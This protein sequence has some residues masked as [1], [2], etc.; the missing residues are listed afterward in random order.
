MET[1]DSPIADLKVTLVELRTMRDEIRV[2]LHLAGMDAK[3][4]WDRDLEPRLFSL[5]KRVE[6]EL[7]AA[8]KTVLHD[9]RHA[10]HAF[11]E[12]LKKS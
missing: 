1:K 7:S 10:M 4:K 8:T 3:E 6:D 11:R 12:A 2:Q 5:E 9:L